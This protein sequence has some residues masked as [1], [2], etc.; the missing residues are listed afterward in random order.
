MQQSAVGAA[1]PEEKI[2]S[3]RNSP[4]VTAEDRGIGGKMVEHPEGRAALSA[5]V[6]TIDPAQD[7]ET[8]LETLRQY[9]KD[10]GWTVTRIYA[11]NSS[12]ADHSDRRV[13]GEL[14]D[15][16][17]SGGIDIVVVTELDRVS[18]STK[19]AIRALV[20]LGDCN[21]GFVDVNGSISTMTTEQFT[22]KATT[23]I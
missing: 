8:Q 14:M 23:E 13:W 20:E 7:P 2:S 15:Q 9:V 4:R 3:G 1:G 17:R 10:K 19:E 5:R 6:S 12:G 16:V 22:L 11:E 21:V 18:R